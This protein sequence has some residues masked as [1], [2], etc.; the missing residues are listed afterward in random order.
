MFDDDTPQSG[1]HKKAA[2]PED[3]FAGV[4]DAPK[5]P[6]PTPST[7]PSASPAAPASKPA[8]PEGDQQPPGGKK[9]R[10]RPKKKHK[11]AEDVPAPAPTNPALD[12]SGAKPLPPGLGENEVFSTPPKPV[13]PAAPAPAPVQVASHG[14][15]AKKMVI[16]GVIVVLVIVAAVLLASLILRSR[17]AV[18]PVSQPA[19]TEP[20]VT[21]PI[22][23]LISNPT[24]LVPNFGDSPVLEND[25]L[26]G[27]GGEPEPE[28]EPEPIDS[29]R[30]G[31]TDEEELS[32]G[33]S[34]RSADTDNDGLSDRDEVKQWGTN[35]LNPDSDADGFLDGEEVNNGYDP[36]GSGRLFEVPS[37]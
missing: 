28:P 18:S 14:G 29:D 16:V 21:T 15:A 4:D 20:T 32:L 31:L 10:R 26:L 5:A 24:D 12:E 36:R 34:P 11:R 25:L 2:P 6:S 33:T 17:K 3:I 1:S 8:R 35:P 30:D 19:V 37:E 23:D 13:A 7:T 27:G 9:R 22:E